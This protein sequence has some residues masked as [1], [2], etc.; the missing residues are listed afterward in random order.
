MWSKSRLEI[1]SS[2]LGMGDGEDQFY[3]IVFFFK[4]TVCVNLHRLYFPI[5]WFVDYAKVSLPHPDKFKFWDQ[6][7]LNWASK[8]DNSDWLTIW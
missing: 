7:V 5:V 6:S 1:D 8:S 3:V 4:P 2:Y